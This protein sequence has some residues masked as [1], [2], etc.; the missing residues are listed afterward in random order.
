MSRMVCTWSSRASTIQ[1]RLVPSARE[2]GPAGADG[3]G[4]AHAR[5]GDD[6]LAFASG[7]GVVIVPPHGAVGT[8]A[9]VADRRLAA[10][11]SS[12]PRAACRRPTP[13]A[14][15]WSAT[16]SPDTDFSFPA[17]SPDGTRIAVIGERRRRHGGLRLHAAR[18]PVRPRPI[19]WSSTASPR[20]P[21]VL[22]LLVARRA[23]ADVP[24]ETSRTALRCASSRPTRAPPAA[25]IR[26]GAPMYWSWADPTRLLVHSGGEGIAG[27]FGEVSPD[28]VATEPAAILAGAF[29]APAVSSDGRFRAFVTPATG[30]GSRSCSRRATGPTRTRSTCSAWPPSHSVPGS[31]D[32]GVRRGRRT[33]PRRRAAGRPAPPD[34][35]RRRAGCGRCSTARSSA[36]FWAPDGK[37]IAAIGVPAPGDD[38]VA[39]DGSRRRSSRRAS[40]CRGRARREAAGSRSSTPRPG[41]S[42]RTG[43]FARLGRSSS[44]R[45]SPTSTSTPSATGCGPRTAR[46]F[47]HPGRRRRRQRPGHGHPGG[48]LRC[49]SGRRRRGRH[50]GV[51]RLPR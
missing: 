42:A 22:P 9:T 29:R 3:R 35:W 51:R 27:F 41:R 24:D 47:A 5:G 2:P 21:A 14:A 12:T 37:T 4:P 15:R 45:S 28:G 19:R 18:K 49:A 36:F 34:G 25:A 26:E 1:D 17:W 48:R 6:V 50:S 33:R 30:H 8:A 16:A 7:R 13:S 39:G 10:R 43:S 23:G 38:N 11:R 44:T 32:T 46:S 31:D 20:P 40:V